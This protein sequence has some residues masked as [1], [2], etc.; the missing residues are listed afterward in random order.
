MASKLKLQVYT[1]DDNIINHLNDIEK[2]GTKMTKYILSLIQKD[3]YSKDFMADDITINKIAM[4]LGGRMGGITMSI[5]S[6]PQETEKEKQAKIEEENRIAKEK[7]EEENRELLKDNMA[8]ILEM[9]NMG[10][11]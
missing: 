8:S 5:P 7:Q 1:S 4:A 11:E 2:N 10:E 9:M 3:M 6:A